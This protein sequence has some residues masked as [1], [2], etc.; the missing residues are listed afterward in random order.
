MSR[1]Q[2]DASRRHRQAV[3]DRADV[4]RNKLRIANCQL[5]DDDGYTPGHVV[6]DH[7]DHRPAAKR[8]MAAIQAA[9]GWSSDRP[10]RRG[11]KKRGG[12]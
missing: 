2:A 12:A 6:C 11:R 3:T 4:Q 5:C 7:I 1:E 8:G 9:M 10:A